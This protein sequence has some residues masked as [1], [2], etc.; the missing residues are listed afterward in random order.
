M[1]ERDKV[2][3]KKPIETWMSGALLALPIM[4]GYLPVGFAYGVLA[5]KAG[6]SVIN[7]LLMSMIVFA[8]SS[9]L[10]VVGLFSAGMAPISI[11]LT[12][13]VVN[14]RHMLMSA[15]L[16]PFLL[17]WRKIELAGFAFQL[18]DETF[19]L[20][21]TRLLKQDSSKQET[22]VINILSQAAWVLG[23]WLGIV[24]GKMITEIESF[25]LDYA[26]PAMFIA[27][28]VMQ[29]KTHTQ[30]VVAVLAGAFSMLFYLTGLNQWHVIFATAIGALLGVWIET[31]MKN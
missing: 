8:G 6:I 16:L 28:L 11:I 23:S 22:F 24:A 27:L 7:T 5:Q 2:I 10:I 17:S 4:L 26:L 18:T 29:I 13:F 25:A 14:L 21:S 30:I 1:A 31:W 9:Q 15:A 19:A 3:N 12:T 20:H